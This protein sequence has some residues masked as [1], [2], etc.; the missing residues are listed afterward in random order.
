[1]SRK[2]AKKCQLN[3]LGLLISEFQE[4]SRQLHEKHQQL[5]AKIRHLPN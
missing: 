3:R 5:S 2:H 1:M 4:I